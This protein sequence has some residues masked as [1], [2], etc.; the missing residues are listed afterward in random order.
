[1]FFP[2]LPHRV[3]CVL[4]VWHVAPFP[5]MVA[6][7]FLA[8][9]SGQWLLSW[10]RA[11]WPSPLRAW[12]LSDNFVHCPSHKQSN[13]VQVCSWWKRFILVFYFSRVFCQMPALWLVRSVSLHVLYH[14]AGYFVKL[15]EDWPS[16]ITNGVLS[17]NIPPFSCL[18]W[19][20]STATL[21][22]WLLEFRNTFVLLRFPAQLST[23]S[24]KRSSGFFS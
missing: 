5:G 19:E 17:V 21:L 16:K 10:G 4:S 13:Q 24:R 23:S 6:V 22:F 20:S 1:M 18:C 15:I 2:T 3:H 9:F 14:V 11:S 8:D 7:P 12:I